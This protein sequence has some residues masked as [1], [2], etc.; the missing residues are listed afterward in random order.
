MLPLL[1]KYMNKNHTALYRD[2]SLAILKN[3]SDSEPQKKSRKSFKIYL[4]DFKKR[5]RHYGP[6]NPKITNYLNIMLNLIYCLTNYNN[7]NSDYLQSIINEY[8]RSTEKRF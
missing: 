3:T 5:F 8:S 7:V 6:I 1:G 4:K 2:Y